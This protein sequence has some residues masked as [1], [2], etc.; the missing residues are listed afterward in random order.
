MDLA[1]LPINSDFMRKYHQLA[2]EY[3]PESQALRIA[4][5]SEIAN[6][7][8][9]PTRYFSDGSIAPSSGSDVTAAHNSHLQSSVFDPARVAEAD[10]RHDGAIGPRTRRAPGELAPGEEFSN[11][12]RDIGNSP[13]GA[14]VDNEIHGF[15]ARN[16]I[17]RNADG[18]VGTQKSQLLS[19][20]R[21]IRDD[22]SNVV[23]NAKDVWDAASAE[24]ERE[25]KARDERIANSD[26][27][28]SREATKEVPTMLPSSGKRR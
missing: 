20:T 11:V 21:Q 7:S 4:M 12:R 26:F 24:S 25:R 9:T 27:V 5:A 17:T 23:E 14:S 16:Q 13:L 2:A 3:G 15:D 19:N 18:T 8:T 10:H 6:Y 1:Q 28:R 22:V